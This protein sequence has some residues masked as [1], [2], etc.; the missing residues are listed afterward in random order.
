MKLCHP[1]LL[2]D[3]VSIGDAV[4]FASEMERSMRLVEVCIPAV[5]LADKQSLC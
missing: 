5:V 1:S 3:E 4:S 2:G